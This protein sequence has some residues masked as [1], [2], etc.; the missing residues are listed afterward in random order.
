VRKS[1]QLVIP[2]AGAGNRFREVGVSTPKPLIE[3]GGLPMLLWVLANFQLEEND[4]VVII[5]QEKDVLPEK[6]K[7]F[8]NKLN[9]EVDFVQIDGL[10]EGPA[11]TV[12]LAVK[13]LLP[14]IPIIV[15]NSDQYVSADMNPFIEGVRQDFASGYILAMKARGNKWSFI[16]RDEDGIVNRVVEKEEISDEATVGIYG[17]ADLSVMKNAIKYLRDNEMTVND[18]YYVAPSYGYLIENNL[19]IDV[20]NIGAHGDSVHGLGTPKDLTAFLEHGDFVK[21]ASAVR[22]KFVDH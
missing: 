12:E 20:F 19:N 8:L 9:L 4:R 14:G 6:L 16:G 22:S 7:A 10:T 17:W 1:V 5:S 15:A 11:A 3:L 21:F 13:K 2:A 18:E